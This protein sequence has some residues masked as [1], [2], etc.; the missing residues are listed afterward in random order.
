MTHDQLLQHF[1]Q[2]VARCRAIMVRKNKDYSSGSGD[3]FANFRASE[4]ININPAKGIMM[5]MLDKLSRLT[6]FI[7]RGQLAVTEESWQDACDDAMNYAILLSAWLRA[8]HMPETIGVCV[9]ST[10]MP[11]YHAMPETVDECRKHF[12][13]LPIEDQADIVKFCRDNG[14]K[15]RQ[16]ARGLTV[17]DA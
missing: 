8:K 12:D 15:S 2:M 10:R 16:A 4:V 9:Q 11:E 13:K 14:K 17:E 1:D 5:R 3:P 7:D 6:S